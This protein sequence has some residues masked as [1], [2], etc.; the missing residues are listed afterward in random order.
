[1]I[2][3]ALL[4]TG[5]L[6]LIC[7]VI[8][9]VAVELEGAYRRWD[10]GGGVRGRALVLFHPSR[11][12]RFTDDLSAAFAKG[13]QAAGLSVE[14]ATL[15]ANTPSRPQGYRLIA[16]VSN[17]YYWTPDLPTL[18]YLRRARFDG[19][20]VVGLMA[21]AGSTIR[22]QKVLGQALREAG[23]ATV[24]T[25]SFWLWRPNDESRSD[26]PNRAI[27]S[28]LA[29]RFGLESGQASLAGPMR[30]PERN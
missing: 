27:A 22:A 16:V 15:T 9:S 4:A 19:I 10:L 8:I 14:L 17:T 11:D 24:E 13:L 2:K 18:R 29:T 21:G 26:K 1:M 7:W 30:T 5:V 6:L 23:A 12:A 3:K 25:R 20:P 28:D